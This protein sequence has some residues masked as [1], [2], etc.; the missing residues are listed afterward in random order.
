MNTT[1]SRALAKDAQELADEQA[2]MQHLTEGT[3]IEPEVSRR[4]RERAQSVTDEIR[5]VHGIID[6]E[7]FSALL[8]DDD[9]P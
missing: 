2:V 8:R 7:T 1:E 6:D 9:E 4:V 5:R 3:P